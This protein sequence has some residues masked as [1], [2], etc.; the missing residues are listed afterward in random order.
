MY[1]KCRNCDHKWNYKGKREFY[2]CCPKCHYLVNI[3][4]QIIQ[5]IDTD[6]NLVTESPKI[7]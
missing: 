6:K 4:K 2:A 1:L 3:K 5:E 7:T